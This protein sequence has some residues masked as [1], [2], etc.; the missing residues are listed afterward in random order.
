MPTPNINFIEEQFNTALSAW[1]TPRV[2]STELENSFI[3]SYHQ[4]HPLAHL[5]PKDFE[6]KHISPVPS[7]PHLESMLHDWENDITQAN[8]VQGK[9]FE[10][11]VGT[12]S[13]PF[14][15]LI[16]DP[17]TSTPGELFFG[18]LSK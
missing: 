14:E 11:G 18:F 17:N 5:T 8:Q 12:S 1:P 16:H 13:N 7:S 3:E 15:T 2:T 4:S 10:S 6:A 9:P